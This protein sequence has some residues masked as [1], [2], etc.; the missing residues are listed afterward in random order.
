MSLFSYYDEEND[1]TILTSDSQ[2]FEGEFEEES[3]LVEE[4]ECEEAELLEMEDD[5]ILREWRERLREIQIEIEEGEGF[6]N[7][8]L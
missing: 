3:V 1:V 5:Q 4:E 2:G 8:L 7:L 6:K